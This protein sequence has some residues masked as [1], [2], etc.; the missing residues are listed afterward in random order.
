[1]S[2]D[3]MKNALHHNKI[4][5][6]VF[7][8]NHTNIKLETTQKHVLYLAF[9]ETFNSF[10]LYVKIADVI[11][12][13]D[14]NFAILDQKNRW[15]HFRFKFSGFR[16]FQFS[17]QMENQ[18]HTRAIILIGRNLTKKVQIVAFIKSAGIIKKS[19]ALFVDQFKE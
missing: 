15:I 2:W 4:D 14:E 12:G 8:S 3:Y 7:I 19:R 11:F 5:S 16:K 10:Y 1:M 13:F 6:S 18:F 9:L 17:K